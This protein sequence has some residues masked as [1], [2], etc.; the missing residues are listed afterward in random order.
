MHDGLLMCLSD[1]QTPIY[2]AALVASY[3]PKVRY[4]SV[5]CQENFISCT[6]FCSSPSFHFSSQLSE[7]Y[8]TCRLSF[9]AMGVLTTVSDLLRHLLSNN[10]TVVVIAAG[11]LSFLVVAVV[12]NVL[13]QLLLKNPNEPPIVFHWV[14]FIGSTISYGIDPFDFFFK[15]REKV[16]ENCLPED[17]E[18]LLTQSSVR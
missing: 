14:P 12:L 4:A 8:K 5:I 15:C 13:S 9:P 6:F 7:Q 1:L 11:L 3:Y 2:S 10:S 17:C 16:L 18:R